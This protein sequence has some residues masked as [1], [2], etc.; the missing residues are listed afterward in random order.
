MERLDRCAFLRPAQITIL[1]EPTS[2]LDAQTEVEVIER[3]R[4]LA[5]KRT[6]ILVSHRLSTVKMADRI[7]AMSGG[8]V[9]EAGSHDELMRQGGTYAR[10]FES[11]A[12]HYQ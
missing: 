1:D 7:Y 11:Q 3:F 12:K 6:A 10:L 8:R 5:A 9:V 4:D 2:A